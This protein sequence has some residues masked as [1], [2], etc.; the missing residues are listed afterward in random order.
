MTQ[1]D[2]KNNFISFTVPFLCSKH[3]IVKLTSNRLQPTFSML[4]HLL[5]VGWQEGIW[6]VEKTEWRVAG[7]VICLE[8]DE[9]LHMT[10]LIPMQLT[11]SCFSKIQIRFTFL[12]PAHPGKTGQGPEG[13][14]TD[15]CACTTSI[16]G[17][18]WRVVSRN[19][20]ITSYDDFIEVDKQW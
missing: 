15:V 10:Q 8:W 13:H 9:D 14:K 2:D 17:K 19:L 12:V 5:L 18:L 11:I 7:M 6:P 16:K 20:L 1:C 4:S 3:L